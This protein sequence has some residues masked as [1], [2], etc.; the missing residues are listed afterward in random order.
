MKDIAECL[1]CNRKTKRNLVWEFLELF[2]VNE[3]MLKKAD[4]EGKEKGLIKV[5]SFPSPSGRKEKGSMSR[6][7][8]SCTH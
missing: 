1:E 3:S 5:L 7:F 4:L 8:L 6:L 2:S